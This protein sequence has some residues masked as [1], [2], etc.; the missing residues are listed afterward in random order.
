MKKYNMFCGIDPSFTGMGVSIIDTNNKKIIFR[1]LSV[2]LG[3]GAFAEICRASEEMVDKFLTINKDM[4]RV[5]ALVGMEIPPVTGMYAVKLWALDTHL[6]NNLVI[7]DKFLFN[8]PYLKFINK[9]YEGKK[10]TRWMIEQIIEVFKD[11]D[12]EIEQTLLDKRGKSRKLTSNEID[13]FLYAV[14]MFVRYSME[15]AT[16]PDITSEILAINDKFLEEKE[17]TLGKKI[18]E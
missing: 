3:H 18:E 12:Y 5:D 15:S 13:S 11:Y 6:Y 17:T 1:E 8:V 4:I 16:N 14:R 10:D 2:E 7:N 9:K